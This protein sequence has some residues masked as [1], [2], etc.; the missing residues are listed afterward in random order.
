MDRVKD[1]WI[2]DGSRDHSSD[3]VDVYVVPGPG[4]GH[5][6]DPLKVAAPHWYDDLTN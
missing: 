4:A 1:D 3:T 5:A 2:V 6:P